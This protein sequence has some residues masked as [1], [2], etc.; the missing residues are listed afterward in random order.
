VRQQRCYFIP[1]QVSE[2]GLRRRV[3][4]RQL[5]GVGQVFFRDV[6]IAPFDVE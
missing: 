4:E 2:T 1:A 3:S 5:D 6:M